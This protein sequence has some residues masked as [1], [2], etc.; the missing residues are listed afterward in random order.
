[1]SRNYQTTSSGKVLILFLMVEY[2]PTYLSIG[3]QFDHT[4]KDNN[5][6]MF[7]HCIF[8]MFFAMIQRNLAC[9]LP[10][11]VGSHQAYLI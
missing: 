3:I 4:L 1:M 8:P 7:A 2:L 11:S 10:L 6:S 9:L 5:P